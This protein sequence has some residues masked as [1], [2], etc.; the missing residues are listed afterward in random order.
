MVLSDRAV[1]S[2]GGGHDLAPA[3]S[4][5]R[6]RGHGGGS[7]A[8]WRGWRRILC[9]VRRCSVQDELANRVTTSFTPVRS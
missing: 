7:W 8:T 5:T 4:P 3:T 6:S 2:Q 1:M 9:H